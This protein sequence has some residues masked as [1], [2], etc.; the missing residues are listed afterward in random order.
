MEDSSR[1]RDTK[2]HRS[3][4]ALT[5]TTLDD[6]HLVLDMTGQVSPEKQATV[7][8]IARQSMAY[9]EDE[10][11][12]RFPH[13]FLIRISK[14]DPNQVYQPLDKTGQALANTPGI[15]SEFM[16]CPIFEMKPK[17][18]TKKSS[19]KVT[20]GRSRGNDVVLRYSCISKHHVRFERHAN[21]E[22]HLVDTESLNGTF[23]DS[24]RLVPNRPYMLNSGREIDL[25][26]NF[27]FF[28]VNSPEMFEYIQNVRP[29]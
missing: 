24:F 11:H 19:T 1:Q 7:F 22:W 17:D 28:F 25:S 10:F 6:G 14:S 3:F 4:K 2:A 18:E 12:R 26:K 21:N 9:N 15:E 13:P 20:V 5:E 23:L 29:S 16:Q 8:D 27:S